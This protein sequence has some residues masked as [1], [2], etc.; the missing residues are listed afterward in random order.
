MKRE[1][2]LGHAN[3][4]NDVVEVIISNPGPWSE[5]HVLAEIEEALLWTPR[6]RCRP[7]RATIRVLNGRKRVAATVRHDREF[8]VTI[9]GDLYDVIQ[10]L[11]CPSW[12]DTTTPNALS[13]KDRRASEALPG[14]EPVVERA[15][16]MSLR[17][18]SIT[19]ELRAVQRGIE[20]FLWDGRRQSIIAIQWHMY[21]RVRDLLDVAEDLIR[22]HVYYSDIARVHWID[23]S[24]AELVPVVLFFPEDVDSLINAARAYLAAR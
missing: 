3:S 14:W 2:V 21:Y 17:R 5:E 12:P 20:I 15:C 7:T 16:C 19:A 8:E 1:I 9:A 23:P 13:H 10:A 4:A 18:G 22:A 11:L 6:D 24:Q